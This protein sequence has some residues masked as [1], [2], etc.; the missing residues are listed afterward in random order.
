MDKKY[1]IWHWYIEYDS[2]YTNLP[3]VKSSAANWREGPI[4][5]KNRPNKDPILMKKQT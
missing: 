5:P 2:V 3:T 1:G 4:E